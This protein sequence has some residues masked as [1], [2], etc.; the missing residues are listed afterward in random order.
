MHSA[1]FETMKCGR[2]LS[3]F[4]YMDCDKISTTY[5]EDDKT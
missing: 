4:F 2:F 3:V 1:H 5:N